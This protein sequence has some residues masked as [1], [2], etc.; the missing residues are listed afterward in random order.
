MVTWEG[1]CVRDSVLGWELDHKW[2]AV[3]AV[4]GSMKGKQ[5]CWS[6]MCSVSWTSRNAHAAFLS[7]LHQFRA[8]GCL[9]LPGQTKHSEKQLFGWMGASDRALLLPAP[10]PKAL[11]CVAALKQAEMFLMW[12]CTPWAG[13]VHPCVSEDVLLPSVSNTLK[14]EK[15][16]FYVNTSGQHRQLSLLSL[17][18]IINSWPNRERLWI[19]GGWENH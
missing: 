8:A 12:H 14:T 2:R 3:P 6:C 9:G 7:F 1:S 16:S 17:Q 15:Y 4:C 5:N 19:C 10:R 13:Q 11:P 18:Y